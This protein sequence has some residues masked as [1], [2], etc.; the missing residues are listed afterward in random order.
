MKNIN[1]KYLLIILVIVIIFSVSWLVYSGLMDKG[2]DQN[3]NASDIDVNN[4]NSGMEANTN[5]AII[6]NNDPEAKKRDDERLTEVEDIRIKLAEYYE[7][8]GNYPESL[9][10]LV[11]EGY[12]TEIPVNPTP[13]GMDY[14]YTPIG[15]L[16]AMFYDLAYSLEVGTE[17]LEPGEHVANPE[18]I[19]FP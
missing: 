14:I 4:L 18:N 15:S 13:G 8:K 9:E 7:D 6:T 10:Q 17:T 11:T 3:V 2:I 5:T 12:F 19:A 1:Q 16:P